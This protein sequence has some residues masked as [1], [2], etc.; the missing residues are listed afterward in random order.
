MLPSVVVLNLPLQYTAVFVLASNVKNVQLGFILQVSIA[1]VMDGVGS[2]CVVRD[3]WL[4][5]P[6][7]LGYSVK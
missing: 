7:W 3:P 4:Q 6:R 1:V 5:M 2:G